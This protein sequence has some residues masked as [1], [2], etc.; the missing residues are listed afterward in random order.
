MRLMLTGASGFVAPYVIREVRHKLG[1]TVE[2][3]ATSYDG[4]PT[5][6]GAL[7]KALDVTDAAA[8][9]AVVVGFRPTHFLHLAGV[10]TLADAAADPNQTWAINVF[11][12][13]NC[14]RAL[15][16][17]CQGSTFIFAGTAIA[18]GDSARSGRLLSED[19]LLQP[20][21]DYGVTK[22]AA[23]LAI[24]AMGHQGVTVL[25]MRPFNHT[26]PG[27]PP[28]FVIPSFA[29]QIARIEK[30]FQPPVMHVG[31]L[32]VARDFLDVRDVARCYVLALQKASSLPS[33]DVFNIASG[34][35]L[36]LRSLLKMLLAQSKVEIAV[37]TD[38]ERIR[39]DEISSFAGDATK[40][41]KLL[42][43][44]AEIEVEL[45]LKDILAYA[46]SSFM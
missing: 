25:R 18:Y 39:V 32:D 7:T 29:D 13:L 8:V 24:G 40:A 42:G 5:M 10:T 41:E 19:D 9:A 33:G 15:I 43:W 14:L 20:N 28:A 3:L 16:R 27:Q 34:R 23:D 11:G 4:A 1:E 30:G 35:S 2:I 6:D 22:A 45:L 12:T 31:N 37:K 36:T 17:Y 21:S 38:P 44:R 46:R 26:G